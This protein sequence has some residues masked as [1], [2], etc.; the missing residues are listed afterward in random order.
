M[1]DLQPDIGIDRGSQKEDEVERQV[2]HIL[3]LTD[4]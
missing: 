3:D 1:S 4:F 2:K